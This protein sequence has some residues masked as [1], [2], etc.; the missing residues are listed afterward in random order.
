MLIDTRDIEI[1][2]RH[3]ALSD[4]AVK[5][6]AASMD[7]I[8]LRHPITV[9]IV[10]EREIDGQVVC[11][12]PVLVA[13]HHRLAAAKELGWS[14]IDCVEVDDNPIEA[15]LWEISENLHRLDL[16]KEQRDEHIRRYAELLEEQRQSGPMVQIES[17]RDDGR[18]HRP[19]S[20][21]TEIA[22]Q[23]GIS[24]KTV[25]RAINRETRQQIPVDQLSDAEVIDRQV[26]A[27]MS[28]WNKA[29]A[30]ARAIIRDQIDTPIMDASYAA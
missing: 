10:D 13:G 14:Q 17:K 23:T 4:D 18:G 11:G 6:L 12:V 22:E 25:T 19:K 7:K 30:E 20:V 5:R 28:A 16:T 24:R 8:G 3:R 1:G 27:V 9:R 29:S 15:E 2:E 21:A 26:N